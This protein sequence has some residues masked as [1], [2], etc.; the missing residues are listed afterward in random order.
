MKH[1]TYQALLFCLAAAT[2]PITYAANTINE[3]FKE[4]KVSGAFNFRYENVGDDFGND[5]LLSLRSRLTF[6]TGAY[7]GFSLLAELEDVTHVL[8]VDGPLPG[9]FEVD[10]EVT[11]VD[12]SYIQ[13]KNDTV[14]AKLGRQVMVFDNQRF[15]GSLGWRQ[16]H[17]T[18]DAASVKF[19]P[20]KGLNV[21]LAYLFQ[22][23]RIFGEEADARSSD[24]IL[25][26]SYNTPVGKIVGYV[27]LLDDE[28]RD[29]Q[30]DTVGLR[31][32]GSRGE[33]NKLLYTLEYADQS[34]TDSGIDFDTDYLF[35]EIG[36]TVSGI[37][38]KLGYEK[39]SSDDGNA[40]FTTPLGTVHAFHGCADVFIGG[41]FNP[42]ALPD[43]IV[44]TYLSLA[45]EIAGVK[46]TAVYH[47]YEADE[48]SD[49]YGSEWNF[50]AAKSFENGVSAGLKYA[51][52]S[53][54][55][56]LES[57]KDVFWAWTS[58]SF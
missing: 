38:G 41:N 25:N 3:A 34:I 57:D 40:S 7:K 10:Q 1:L 54:D 8:G 12:Q 55:G 17:Q 28:L 33:K 49:S 19:Q 23:N 35:A 2:A 53:D 47:D 21:D 15:I 42:A 11:E 24:T 4:T 52:Y 48:G 20:I 58:Y 32:T 46:L 18:F 50:L 6:T 31:F 16:D 39:L 51:D 5:E 14:S 27:Y 22:R 29:E 30:S 36:G 45:G 26:S 56:F 9:P 43:G 37:T 13:F 44:D